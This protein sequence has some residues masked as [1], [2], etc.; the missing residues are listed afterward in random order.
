M[1]PVTVITLNRIA[2]TT[3]NRRFFA[4]TQEKLMFPEDDKVFL[5]SLLVT[6]SRRRLF[7]AEQAVARTQI[8]SFAL[9]REN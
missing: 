1:P 8:A 2:V 6:A 5:S 9:A 7:A 4:P 3:L